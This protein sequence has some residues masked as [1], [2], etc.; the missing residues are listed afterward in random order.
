MPIKKNTFALIG[1]D[2]NDNKFEILPVINMYL[3]NIYS[4]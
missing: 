3:H 2:N 4:F 1:S